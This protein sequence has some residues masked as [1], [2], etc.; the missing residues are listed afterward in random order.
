M[1]PSCDVAMSSGLSVSSGVCGDSGFDDGVIDEYD[2]LYFSGEPGLLTDGFSLQH[3]DAQSPQKGTFL[4]PFV[5]VCPC[6]SGHDSLANKKYR[7]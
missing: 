5:S 6:F 2:N 1:G 7:R 4:P 3:A